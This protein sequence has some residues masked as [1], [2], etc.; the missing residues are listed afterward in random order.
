[1]TSPAKYVSL[2]ALSIT[3]AAATTGCSPDGE[4]LAAVLNQMISDKALIESFVHDIKNSLQA[5]DP[6]YEQMRG[7]YAE[8]RAAQEAYLTAVQLAADTSSPAA[9]LNPI[10]TQLQERATAFVSQGVSVLSPGTSVRGMVPANLVTL[11]ALNADLMK[12]PPKY[13]RAAMTELEQQVR[14]RPWDGI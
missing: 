10:I 2:L 7:L 11:P 12:L 3:L 4:K 6:A 14:W 5:S 9:T 13:R 8:V 1:M